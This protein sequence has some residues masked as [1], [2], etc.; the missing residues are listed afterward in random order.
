MAR[1][2]EK[3]QSMLFRFRAQQATSSGL[4][5]ASGMRRPRNTNSVDSI[6]V[7]EKWRGL[8]LKE[9]SRKV[10][11]IQDESLS[12]SQVRDLND[13]INKAMKEKWNWERRIRELGGPNY[14]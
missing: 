2:A 4:L 7:C 11:R 8:I 9:I 1:N 6:P 14:M 3:A 5:P 13:E 10:T 12:D